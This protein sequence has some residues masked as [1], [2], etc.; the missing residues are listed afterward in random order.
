MA[1]H[2]LSFHIGIAFETV[3]CL[4]GG[5]ASS[6]DSETDLNLTLF[7]IPIPIFI[8]VLFPDTSIF[9]TPITIEQKQKLKKAAA[10]RKGKRTKAAQLDRMIAAAVAKERN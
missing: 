8:P 1:H 4:G 7:H 3:E 10:I 5:E 9:M 6:K 2:L